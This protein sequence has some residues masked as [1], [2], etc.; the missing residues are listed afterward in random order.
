MT[1]THVRPSPHSPLFHR[2]LLAY[3]NA[4]THEDAARRIFG[5]RSTF[6]SRSAVHKDP[7]VL[8]RVVELANPKPDSLALD[9]APGSGHTAAALAPYVASVVCADI[10]PQMIREA[11]KI[12]FAQGFREYALLFSRCPLSTLHG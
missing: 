8:K 10:T 4:M 12:S 11:Q 1:E 5:E 9:V 3:V 7:E 2:S 6:Y